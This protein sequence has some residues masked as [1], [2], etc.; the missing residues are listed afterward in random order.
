MKKIA[1]IITSGT[2]GFMVAAGVFVA[3]SN[4]TAVSTATMKTD[5]DAVEV[6]SLDKGATFNKIVQDWIFDGNHNGGGVAKGAAVRM[7]LTGKPAAKAATQAKPP[8]TKT[9][10]PP[11][12]SLLSD[13]PGVKQKGLNGL[14]VSPDGNMY[15]VAKVSPWWKFW[16][17]NRAIQKATPDTE[18]DMWNEKGE[19]VGDWKTVLETKAASNLQVVKGQDGQDHLYTQEGWTNKV[20]RDG[21]Y[22]TTFSNSIFSNASLIKISASADDKLYA[23][24]SK[25]SEDI[26]MMVDPATQKPRVVARVPSEVHVDTVWRS[27]TVTDSDGDEHTEYYTET[28]VTRY[29]VDKFNV[30][31]DGRVLTQF[32]GNVFEEGANGNRKMLAGSGWYNPLENVPTGNV[33]DFT[34]DTH[35]N[36][37]TVQ[38]GHV[39]ANN[40][41]ISGLDLGWGQTLRVDDSGNVYT[42]E[43]RIFD[44]T[45][46][47]RTNMLPDA[48]GS[49]D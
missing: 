19:F 29:G 46:L 10:A 31:A 45:Y 13:K 47:T 14:V 49:G 42:T 30:S 37:Y 35:G 24:Y 17:S 38:G 26:I 43:T 11:L 9:K 12:L 22:V 8:A 44:G 36:L 16:D 7:S 34:V 40:N 23:Q 15:R 27:R 18:G 4:A 1:K 28:V 2:C 39:H 32:K 5:I 48:A 21:K 6:L 3:G 41:P 33:S 20:Y 25:N